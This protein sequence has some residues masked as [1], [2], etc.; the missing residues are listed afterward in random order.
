VTSAHGGLTPQS[1]TARNFSLI[2]GP[3]PRKPR[4]QTGAAHICRHCPS[5]ASPR[6]E[7][8]LN[9]S[10]SQEMRD[11]RNKEKN[12]KDVEDDFRNAG[13]GDGDA[14]EPKHSGNDCDHESLA[15]FTPL[16]G[17]DA[18]KANTPDYGHVP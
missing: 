14:T 13:R 4:W 12:E 2:G 6:Q 8:R 15:C 10:P 9:V 17:L 11:Q 1:A 16:Y 18:R 5:P 7:D 3:T